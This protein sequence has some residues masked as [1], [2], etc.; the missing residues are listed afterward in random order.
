LLVPRQHE[1]DPRAPQR[2]DDVEVLLA[3]HAEDP[4][5]TL[6]LQR[7][8]QQVRSLCHGDTPLRA[9]PRNIPP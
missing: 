8:D 3:R 9:K 1:L 6:I 4:L 5:D 7:S 2:F